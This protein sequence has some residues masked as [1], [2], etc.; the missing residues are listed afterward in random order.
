MD[1]QLIRQTRLSTIFFDNELRQINKN[2][3]YTTVLHWDTEWCP[4]YRG[5]YN[6]EVRNRE[7]PLYTVSLLC[8]SQRNVHLDL[9]LRT[10]TLHVT[11]VPEELT[12]MR[13]ELISV[14]TVTSSGPPESLEPPQSMIVVSLCPCQR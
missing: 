14:T 10:A 12:R 3:L 13:K 6:L 9:T 2:L 7:A 1:I 11:C 5:F 4:Y 8:S